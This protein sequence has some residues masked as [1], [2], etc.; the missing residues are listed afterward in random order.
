MPMRCKEIGFEDVGIK[1]IK[2]KKLEAGKICARG[3]EELN[4][5]RLVK[6]NHCRLQCDDLAMQ[7]RMDMIYFLEMQ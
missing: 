5:T 6:A 1:E 3:C 4:E 7:Y 2:K